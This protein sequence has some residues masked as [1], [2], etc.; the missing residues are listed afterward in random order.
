M[1]KKTAKK[2]EPNEIPS[3]PAVFDVSKPGETAAHPTSRPV[4]LGHTSMLKKDPMV[5]PQNEAVVS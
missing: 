5:S 3:A 1:T 2:D 4:I